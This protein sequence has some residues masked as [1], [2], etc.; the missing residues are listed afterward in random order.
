MTTTSRDAHAVMPKRRAGTEDTFRSFSTSDQAESDRLDFWMASAYRSVEA[1]PDP[2]VALYG[3]VASCEGAGAQFIHCTS[4][5][6]RTWLTPQRVRSTD[7]HIA[8][9]LLDRGEYR[10]EQ[11]DGMRT[12]VRAGELF[13]F[14]CGQPMSSDWTESSTCYLRLPRETV[15][16]ALGHDPANL[17]RIATLL[18]ASPLAPFVSMQLRMLA[19]HGPR[20]D[21][22]ALGV[23]MESTV[24]MALQLIATHPGIAR[25]DAGNAQWR[26][27]KLQ[28]Q[29]AYRFME[30]HAHQHDLTPDR[31]AAFLHCSRAQLY[32]LFEG[33][34]LRVMAALREIR[35]RR[36]R[37][38]LERAGKSAHIGAIAHDCGFADPSAFGKLF[39]ERFGMTPR[40]AL[41][42]AIEPPRLAE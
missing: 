1:R 10:V 37:E 12:V 41:A 9:C 23:V 26:S 22:A 31:I 17:G 19:A 42:G 18:T 11:Q 20:L 30:Q 7:E 40:Q 4:S 39:R 6:V 29:A 16:Q 25:A 34:P 32:R 27:G 13:M 14:D 3:S 8:I 2:D 5:A 36:S 21:R 38:Y 33:E 28:L 15:R 35:L 24:G